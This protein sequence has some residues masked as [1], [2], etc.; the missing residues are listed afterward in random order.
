MKK[1]GLVAGLLVVVLCLY[2]Q[3]RYPIDDENPEIIKAL[4]DAGINMEHP[5][6]LIYTEPFRAAI[7]EKTPLATFERLLELGAV[8]EPD[9]ALHISTSPLMA[10]VN[11]DYFEAVDFLIRHDADVN[12]EHSLKRVPIHQASGAKNPR[13]LERLIQAGADVNQKDEFGNT[14]LHFAVGSRL[15]ENIRLLLSHGA[16]V[17]SKENDGDT[18]LIS[19]VNNFMAD[20]AT[21]QAVLAGRPDI[22]AVNSQGQSALIAAARDAGNPEIIAILLNA[23]ANAKLEDNTGRT[24]LDWFDQNRRISQSPVR[25]E[26]RDRM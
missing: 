3:D 17:N 8:V 5:Y 25:K 20:P 24:A 1:A 23:G 16:D 6:Y 11:A 15:P 13:M 21:V 18:P 22:N 12:R 19:A 4:K 14:P 2:A 9:F 10:A 7:D 26:L